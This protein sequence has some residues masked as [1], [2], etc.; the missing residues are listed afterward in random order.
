MTQEERDQLEQ[1]EEEQ[2]HMDEGQ[3][4]EEEENEDEGS[5]GD[6]NQRVMGNQVGMTTDDYEEIDYKIC[7]ELGKEGYFEKV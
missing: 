6:D 5:P 3:M 1:E 4:D 7:G 2:D